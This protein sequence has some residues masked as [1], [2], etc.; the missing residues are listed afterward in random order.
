MQRSE[1]QTKNVVTNDE[2]SQT[3]KNEEDEEDKRKD[4]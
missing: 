3:V 2:G 1:V 4:G